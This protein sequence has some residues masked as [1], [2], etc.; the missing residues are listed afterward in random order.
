MSEIVH[1]KAIL[2][3]KFNLFH[4]CF[5]CVGTNDNLFHLVF[6]AKSNEDF[7]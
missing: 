2:N 5:S 7:I 1:N 3:V 4:L 6:Y